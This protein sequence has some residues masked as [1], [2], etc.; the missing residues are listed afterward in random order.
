MKF[1][2]F[3]AVLVLIRLPLSASLLV[4]NAEKGEKNELG[5]LWEVKNDGLRDYKFKAQKKKGADSRYA[6]YFKVK[7]KD[8][9]PLRY[10]GIISKLTAGEDLF[11]ASG[12]AGVRFRAKGRGVAYFSVGMPSTEM[13][14]SHYMVRVNLTG[15]WQLY[16]IPLSAL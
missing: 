3:L 10:S 13:D 6:R 11:D 4:D 15:K 7:L 2:Q 9:K 8:A 5:G 1:L 12:Y 16:Q 14:Y